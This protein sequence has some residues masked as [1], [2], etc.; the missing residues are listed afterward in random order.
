MSTMMLWLEQCWCVCFHLRLS[1]YNIADNSIVLA[2]KLCHLILDYSNMRSR[3]TIL[4][5]QGMSVTSRWE[6]MT[7]VLS[8]DK[9]RTKSI[10]KDVSCKKRRV[11]RCSNAVFALTQHNDIVGDATSHHEPLR[12]CIF[13]ITSTGAIL[14]I[15][16]CAHIRNEY[17]RPCFSVCDDL[18][19]L[20]LY[21]G[22]TPHRRQHKTSQLEQWAVMDEWLYIALFHLLNSTSTADVPLRVTL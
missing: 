1:R 9:H 18:Q 3:R 2:W 6:R 10:R 14:V 8:L 5:T 20:Q 16:L 12:L 11:L 7:C 13:I 4:Q 22:K 19:A 17:Q 15:T 21:I